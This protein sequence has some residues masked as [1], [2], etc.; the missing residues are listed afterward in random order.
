M[1]LTTIIPTIGRDTLERAVNSVLNQAF[2]ADTLEVIVVNDTGHPLT[3]EPWMDEPNVQVVTTNKHRQGVAR[4]VGAAMG[5]GRYLHF[6][7]D[8]DWMAPGAVQAFWDAVQTNP[9][10]WIYGRAQ[11]M[12]AGQDNLPQI[13]LGRS[14]NCAVHIMAGEWIPMGSYIVSNKSFFA[15]GGFNPLASPGEDIAFCRHLALDADF[16]SI[17]VNVVFLDRGGHSS[18][19]Y[20]LALEL[21]RRYRERALDHQHAFSR[22]TTSADDPFWKGRLSRIYLTSTIWN[23]KEKQLTTA[24]TRLGRGLLVNLFSGFNL[25]TR[26]FWQGVLSTHTS[27][28]V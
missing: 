11:L 21:S 28:T 9:A 20:S 18:T 27:R 1:F 14:G 2:E 5:H 8:D 4:N 10:D 22:L 12:E 13:G 24:A 6:L 25:F 17:P 7:D 23:V 15:A 19:D 26:S 3:P 16:L